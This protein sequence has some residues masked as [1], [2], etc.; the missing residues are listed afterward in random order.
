MLH[1]R[2]EFSLGL[3]REALRRYASVIRPPTATSESRLEQAARELAG[4]RF[5]R[6][7]YVRLFPRISTATASRDL[8]TGVAGGLLD[9]DGD[10]ARTRYRFS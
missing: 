3:I 2:V 4:R 7:H 9:R 6:A 10:R 8:L 1:R 5:A